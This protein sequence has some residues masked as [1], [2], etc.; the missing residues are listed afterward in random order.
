MGKVVDL[1][2]R[3]FGRLTVIK[4]SYP[5]TKWGHTRWLCKCSCGKEKIITGDNLKDGDTKSCGCLKKGIVCLSLGLANMRAKINWY[6]FNARKKG[7]RY[8]LTEKQFKNL[9]QQDCHYCGLSPSNICNGKGTF[10][11]YTYNGLDRIDNNKGYIVDNV[12]SC[13]KTC[14]HAKNNSTIQEF[15]DWSERLYKKMFKEEVVL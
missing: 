10:G 3:K 8:T 1:T 2:G 13:C 11:T 9:T 12:V 15:K 14:N 4:R 5:N 7:L 6:K